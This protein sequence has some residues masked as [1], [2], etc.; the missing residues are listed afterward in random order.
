MA[1]ISHPSLEKK[2]K[3]LQADFLILSTFN[4]IK[5]S[6]NI[7]SPWYDEKY[8][9]E[10][11]PESLTYEEL[12]EDLCSTSTIELEEMIVSFRERYIKSFG[13]L[14]RLYILKLKEAWYDAAEQ[15]NQGGN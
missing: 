15:M 5:Y 6:H 13:L 4:E 3:A 14:K 10:D 7:L 11:N 9:D 12:M 8:I 1:K 2:M